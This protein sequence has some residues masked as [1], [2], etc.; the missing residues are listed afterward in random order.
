[1]T[2]DAEID[3]E[4]HL[5]GIFSQVVNLLFFIEVSDLFVMLAKLDQRIHKFDE[6]FEKFCEGLSKLDEGIAE[7]Q[8]GIEIMEESTKRMRQER[9]EYRI[10]LEERIKMQQVVA[11]KQDETSLVIEELRSDIEIL[12]QDQRN[13]R[14]SSQQVQSNVISCQG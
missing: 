7:V 6:E 5:P 14:N 9:E 8:K 4:G 10:K 12:L 13:R 3:H 2:S 11:Q 1:M